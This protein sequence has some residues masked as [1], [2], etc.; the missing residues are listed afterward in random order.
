VPVMR[1]VAASARLFQAAS[2]IRE[3]CAIAHAGESA[4]RW[5]EVG[6]SAPSHP[7]QPPHQPVEILPALEERL[8]AD[9]LVLAVGA[10]G[11]PLRVTVPHSNA[12]LRT[13]SLHNSQQTT[14]RAVRSRH[15][16][17]RDLLPTRKNFL[18]RRPSFWE[19][20]KRQMEFFLLATS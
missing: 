1:S 9:A 13:R 10:V 17:V 20:K 11:L 6:Q 15:I 12:G 7:T 19:T 16:T 4:W 3:S 5:A 14:A 8:D 2:I 18:Q